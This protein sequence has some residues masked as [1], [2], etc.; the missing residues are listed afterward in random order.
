MRR[1]FGCWLLPLLLDLPYGGPSSL[2]MVSLTA[3]LPEC[4]SLILSIFL[5]VPIFFSRLQLSSLVLP[6]FSVW[7]IQRWRTTIS[8]GIQWPSVVVSIPSIGFSLAF[9]S[10]TVVVL[11][12]GHPV[13]W[14]VLQGYCH[15][16][17][18]T[19]AG[20]STTT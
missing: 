13:S 9:G 6:A 5:F 12:I 19:N 2:D 18:V 4:H 16:Q 7:C 11:R 1:P 3:P 10:L 15:W 14:D 20:E 8:A 17:G